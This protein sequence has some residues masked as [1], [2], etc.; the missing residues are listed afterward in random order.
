[1]GMRL[2]SCYLLGEK[3]GKGSSYVLKTE[4]V[5]SKLREAEEAFF[6]EGLGDDRD[7]YVYD[8][9]TVR[10]AFAAAFLEGAIIIEEIE[11][12]ESRIITPRDIGLWFNAETSRWGRFIKQRLGAEAFEAAR[13]AVS[14]ATADGKPVEWKWRSVLARAYT[15]GALPVRK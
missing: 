1:M 4:N 5:F 9:E 12:S 15:S 6:E 8:A 11:Q 10:R 13:E 2:S 7:K 14:A 3:S